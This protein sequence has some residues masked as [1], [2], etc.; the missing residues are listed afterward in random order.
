MTGTSGLED[1]S[2]RLQRIAKQSRERPEMVWTTL[3]HHI[4]VELLKEAYRRTRKD[5]STGIDHETAKA[6]A[7][8]LEANLRSLNERFHSGTYRAPP[9]RRCYIPKGNGK[10]YRPIGIPT[11]EDKILQRAVAM[12]L[13]AVYEQEFL[14]GSYGFRPGRS[15]H[16]ALEGLRE[17]TALMKGAHLVEVD[18]EKFFDTLDHNRLR[19]FL[20]LRVRDGNLRRIIDKWLSTGVLEDGKLIHPETGTPQGGVISPLLANIYLHHV[21]DKWFEEVVKPR[22]S[23]KA[24]LIRYADDMVIACDEERDARRIMEVLPKRFG[25][26]GLTLH[27]KKTRLVWFK[28]PTGSGEDRDSFDFLGFTHYWGKSRSGYWVIRKKTAKGRLTRAIKRVAEFCR[29]FRHRP[30]EWQHQKLVV[31]L[32]GHCGYYG[33]TGNARS[34]EQF[35]EEVRKLWRKWLNRRAQHRTMYWDRYVQLLKSYPLPAMRVVHSIYRRDSPVPLETIKR[36]GTVPTIRNRRERD[37]CVFG[38]F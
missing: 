6:Y 12:I 10:D 24:F 38:G 1:I 17:V 34:L 25:R 19:D 29:L 31:K 22:L 23:R 26:Y 14:N 13:E 9:V 33:V 16:Q 30:L 11:T 15:A 20:D 32:K 27:P 35:R 5:G 3:A 4:D 7:K 21:I 2:T 28:K 37:S 36:N 18:I 8:N